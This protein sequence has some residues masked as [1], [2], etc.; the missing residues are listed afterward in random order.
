[1]KRE[2]L[3][4]VIG[5]IEDSFIQEAE[6]ETK[7]IVQRKLFL[8]VASW[9]WTAAVA[10]ILVLLGVNI[11]YYNQNKNGNTI[12]SLNENNYIA[13]TIA[14]AVTAAD[15]NE[16]G[17]KE[18]I[19]EKIVEMQEFSSAIDIDG[20]NSAGLESVY[21]WKEHLVS[22]YAEVIEEVYLIYGENVLYLNLDKAFYLSEEQTEAFMDVLDLND[23]TVVIGNWEEFC[24]QGIIDEQAEEI[25]G[26]YIEFQVIEETKDGF[27]FQ[28]NCWG[29]KNVVFGWQKCYAWYQED[30]WKVKLGEE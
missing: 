2:R 3:F 26:I 11:F 27:E 7:Q 8:T 25:A 17:E 4:R 23:I 15:N 14:E 6:E 5:M 22:F 24:E 19:E 10:G 21:D 28:I 29:G 13:A 16:G 20:S 30:G 9:K 12:T 1:M 18:Q